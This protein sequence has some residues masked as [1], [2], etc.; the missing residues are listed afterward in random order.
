MPTAFGVVVVLHG[1]AEDYVDLS[2]MHHPEEMLRASSQVFALLK[3]QVG[4]HVNVLVLA[5][6]AKP[7]VDVQEK[8]GS[9]N[10]KKIVSFLLLYEENSTYLLCITTF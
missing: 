6:V 7:L 1:H 9:N 3:R 5:R 2:E 8:A 10:L 4:R